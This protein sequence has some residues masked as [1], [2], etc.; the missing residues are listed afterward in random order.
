[1]LGHLP[2]D[3]GGDGC[4]GSRTVFTEVA[5]DGFGNGGLFHYN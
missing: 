2:D 5:A 4:A 3:R 1:M